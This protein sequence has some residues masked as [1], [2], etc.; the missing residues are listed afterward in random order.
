MALTDTEIRKAKAKASAYRMTDGGGLYIYR[1]PL[2]GQALA[3][4]V[5]L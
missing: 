5:S 4:E 3:L 1:S 2:L